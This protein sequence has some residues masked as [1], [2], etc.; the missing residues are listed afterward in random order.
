M[1][2]LNPSVIL[3]LGGLGVPQ[4][5]KC[6]VMT[7]V[8]SHEGYVKQGCAYYIYIYTKYERARERER[9]RERER[10]RERE[11]AREKAKR[12]GLKR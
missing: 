12:S 8:M 6:N 1:T 7:P 3:T 11:R 5:P 4:T 9:E 2:A 10:D